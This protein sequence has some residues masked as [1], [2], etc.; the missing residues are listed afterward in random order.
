MFLFNLC[1]KLHIRILNCSLVVTMKLKGNKNF[2]VILP[3]KSSTL[4][5]D[6]LPCT[7]QGPKASDT[8]VASAPPCWHQMPTHTSVKTGQ[9]LQ[10]IIHV[11]CRPMDKQM[12]GQ[13]GRWAN[14]Y[15]CI[16]M[17]YDD[18]TRLHFPSEGGKGG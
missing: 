17:Q 5:Q 14:T 12:Y 10:K 6:M 1:T 18:L 13:A 16:H 15:T 7:F 8:S 2:H 9:L 3:L 11:G 4:F